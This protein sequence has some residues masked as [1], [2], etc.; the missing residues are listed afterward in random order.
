WLAV[1]LTWLCPSPKFPA[2]CTARKAPANSIA[3]A[4]VLRPFAARFI[5]ASSQFFQT[6]RIAFAFRQ[7][8]AVQL[9]SLRGRGS[10]GP[11]PQTAAR[12]AHLHGCRDTGILSW[13]PLPP[14]SNARNSNQPFAKS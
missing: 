7:L 11:S 10:L 8:Q 12:L 4:T 1:V 2:P 14:N 6:P 5:L 13:E 3:A 9:K